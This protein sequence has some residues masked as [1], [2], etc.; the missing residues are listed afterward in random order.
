MSAVSVDLIAIRMK[1]STEDKLK[2]C[3]HA[4]VLVWYPL[5]SVVNARMVRKLCC[6]RT[7]LTCAVCATDYYST[8]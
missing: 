5:C 8:A 3:F 2:Q 1:G 6:G 4:Y 7:V